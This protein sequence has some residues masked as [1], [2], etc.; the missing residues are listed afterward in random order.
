MGVSM[1]AVDGLN[2]S[3]FVKLALSFGIPTFIVG[4][5]DGNVKT[6]IEAQIAKI[7]TSTGLALTDDVFGIDFLSAGNDIEAELIL[8]LN[9][10]D[11]VIQALISSATRGSDNTQYVAAKTA[12]INALSNEELV[13]QMRAGKASYSGFLSEVIV[14][15]PQ[16]RSKEELVPNA[17][18]NA[19]NK[20]KEWL[21]P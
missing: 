15:S 12:E 5:N 3:P 18:F 11:E 16:A 17:L 1:I 20:V 14:K 9:L 21:E 10:R 6:T 7:P 19:F 4:D 2:Y 13:E 8:A